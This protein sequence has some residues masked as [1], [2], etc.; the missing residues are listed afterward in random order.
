LA[1]VTTLPTTINRKWLFLFAALS[2]TGCNSTVSTNANDYVGEYVFKPSNAAP[3]DFASFLVLKQDHTA[4]EVRFSKS[5]GQ[6]PTTQEKWYLSH[7]TGE[8]IVIGNFSHP[9]E[10]SKSMIKRG[11]NNDLG[12]YYEKVR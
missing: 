4:I 7:T 1:E 11:I 10:R 3:G 2:A 6:I 12:E 5:T 9:I 8:N